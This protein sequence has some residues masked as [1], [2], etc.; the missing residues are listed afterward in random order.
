MISTGSEQQR[1]DLRH[2]LTHFDTAV[3]NQTPFSRQTRATGTDCRDMVPASNHALKFVAPDVAPTS[4]KAGHS[5]S[6]PVTLG[7][8]CDDRIQASD[9]P[10]ESPKTNKKALFAAKTNKAFKG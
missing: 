5:E 2:Q 8:L 9:K 1:R 10:K 6:F 4:G 3:F 7:S